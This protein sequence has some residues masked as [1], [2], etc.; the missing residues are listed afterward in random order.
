MLAGYGGYAIW[1]FILAILAEL[2]GYNIYAGCVPWLC[3][4]A[5]NAAYARWLCEYARWLSMLAVW[6]RFLSGWLANLTVWPG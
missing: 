3:C 5:V 1:I 2:A 6:L 4:L